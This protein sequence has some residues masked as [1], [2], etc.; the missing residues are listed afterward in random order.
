[1]TA[2]S[3]SGLSGAGDS[4]GKWKCGNQCGGC[5]CGCGEE[6]PPT[7]PRKRGCYTKQNAG[8]KSNLKTGGGSNIKVC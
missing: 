2:S 7:P 4:N 5:G 8:N 1:M 6:T 3:I